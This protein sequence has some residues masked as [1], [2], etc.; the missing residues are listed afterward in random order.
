M[1]VVR[2]Y[3]FSEA[4]AFIVLVFEGLRRIMK[5]FWLD[6]KRQ[7]E[8]T[9]SFADKQ[10]KAV[11]W[12]NRNAYFC[13]KNSSLDW[14]KKH[15]DPNN[16]ERLQGF[17]VESDSEFEE[18]D[19][20]PTAYSMIK[21]ER[22]NDD[23]KTLLKNYWRFEHREVDAYDA[24]TFGLVQRLQNYINTGRWHM[25][26]ERILGR[27]NLVGRPITQ[28]FSN[29]LK[30]YILKLQTE[31]TTL[32]QQSLLE[33]LIDKVAPAEYA[34][35]S[36]RFEHEAKRKPSFNIMIDNID[37]MI[38]NIDIDIDIDFVY[39]LA[40][41]VYDGKYYRHLDGLAQLIKLSTEDVKIARIV[42]RMQDHIQDGSWYYYQEYL[43]LKG[44]SKKWCDDFRDCIANIPQGIK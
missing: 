18:K 8:E 13:S 28:E 14:K 6:K 1:V 2:R 17:G 36:D 37:I 32:H 30:H 11:F 4:L 33:K 34:T 10:S 7:N 39:R 21:L 35:L 24:A 16:N 44:Y 19:E 31:K 27:V 25:I 26:E 38:D 40:A 23:V 12:S 9:L 3:P 15:T 41:A 22:L 43:I 5:N 20:S 42:E 29:K